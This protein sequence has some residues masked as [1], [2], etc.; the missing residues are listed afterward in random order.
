MMLAPQ[1]TFMVLTKRPERMAKYF[2]LYNRDEK[3]G[4]EAMYLY[5]Q[6]GGRGD[7]SLAAGLIYGQGKTS[8]LPHIPPHPE[9]W[10]L[11]NV[12]LGVS[13]ENQRVADER[14]PLLLQTPAAVRFLSMEPLLGPV[15]LSAF[16]PFDGECYCSDYRCCPRMA[17]DCPETAID[18]VIVGGESGPNARPMHPDWVRSLRDQCKEVGV[19]FFLKQMGEWAIGRRMYEVE[20]PGILNSARDGIIAGMTIDPPEERGKARY[21]C[22]DSEGKAF[23]MVRVGKKVAGRVLDGRTWDEFPAG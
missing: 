23:E 17:K 1:H 18:W 10:P 12:W 11:P 6:F 15:D 5:E 9:A 19:P 14:I 20:I 16:K 3:I 2:R 13:V 7:C 8:N 4:H 22:I 21:I